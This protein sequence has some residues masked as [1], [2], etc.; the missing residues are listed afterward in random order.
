[1]KRKPKVGT[2]HRHWRLH[3]PRDAKCSRFSLDSYALPLI[4]RDDGKLIEWHDRL[5]IACVFFF[6]FVIFQMKKK[7][8]KRTAVRDVAEHAGKIPRHAAGLQRARILLRRR[9]ERVFLRPRPGHLPAH[10]Q[11]LPDGQIALPQTRMPDQLRRGAGLLRHRAGRHRRL[12][13]RGLPR[14]QAGERR[15]HHGRQTER[16]QRTELASGP[17]YA[18]HARE[19]VARLRESA[20]VDGRPRL[21]LRHRLLHRRQ[22]HGQRGGNG[23]VHPGHRHAPG[24]RRP[25]LVQEHRIHSMRREIQN[26]LLLPRHGMRHDLHCWILAQ[27]MIPFNNSFHSFTPAPFFN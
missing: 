23:A 21:L 26:H 16:E 27:V 22:R 17:G 6:L 5:L 20:H 19:N 24:R 3:R 8:K 1:M 14:P 11:L 18:Q 13:L 10:P 12:L 4:A 25:T 15:A 2:C 9:D 7:K